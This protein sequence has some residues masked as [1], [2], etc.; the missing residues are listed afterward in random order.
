MKR[1]LIPMV[2]SLYVLL[3]THSHAQLLFLSDSVL[4]ELD[5]ST[6]SQKLIKLNNLAYEYAR[7]NPLEGMQI[8]HEAIKLAKQLKDSQ[9]LATAYGILGI[10]Y[11]AN[12]QLIKALEYEH[13]AFDIYTK[14]Q[15]L[16]S[17]AAMQVNISSIYLDLS[18]YAAALKHCQSALK[19]YDSTKSFA[20]AGLTARQIG[21]I[22]FRL[23]NYTKTLDYFN[24]AA[25]YYTT[26][27]DT[28]GL[29]QLKNNFGIYYNAIGDYSM[30]ISAHQEG[31]EFASKS[32]NFAQ[33]GTNL[34][35]LANALK[36]INQFDS[37]LRYFD[38]AIEIYTSIEY[39]LGVATTRGN[40]GLT[41]VDKASNTKDTRLRRSLLSEAIHLLEQSVDSC[42]A[43]RA[44]D[45]AYEFILG[46][47]DAYSSKGDYKSAFM[48]HKKYHNYLD[49]MT[50]MEHLNSLAG[51]EY[52]L[53]IQS[54]ANK[55]S[56][57]AAQLEINKLEANK[58]QKTILIYGCLVI[59]LALSIIILSN[60]LKKT[61][62]KYSTTLKDLEM[63]TSKSEIQIKNL[64][65]HA[66][67]L[68]DIGY[69]QAHQVRGPVTTLLSM[70]DLYN[71][72][73][74]SDPIN[75][76]L[77]DNMEMVTKKL[78]TAVQ[79]VIMKGDSVRHYEKENDE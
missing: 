45:P 17:L 14:T 52:E 58:S 10:N 3:P 12:S 19:Y 29:A 5:H 22:H 74:P 8:A 67:V 55:L 69:M 25:D 64:T 43:I 62:S 18:N 26:I 60:Y 70:A 15:N 68:K 7:T 54:K 37:A 31:F 41:L 73:N 44:Q 35:N 4:I 42:L 6:K 56:A 11:K 78:D 49:S 24:K 75:Q 59:I 16:H 32:K 30:A 21:T 72:E 38:K 13:R 34:V 47:C 27:A 63:L 51:V 23:K 77:I 61:R 46:L 65:K 79:A 50:S 33:M 36:N 9:S 1:L 66:E 28:N 57:L 20:H 76:Y 48:L 53:E 40:I 39:P 2:I 71:R